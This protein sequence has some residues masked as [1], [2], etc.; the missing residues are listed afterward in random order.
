MF[1]TENRGLPETGW[2]LL[3]LSMKRYLLLNLKINL[4]SEIYCL[5]AKYCLPKSCQMIIFSYV[6]TFLQEFFFHLVSSANCCSSTAKP[7]RQAVEIA[8][9]CSTIGLNSFSLSNTLCKEGSQAE[10]HG[11][12]PGSWACGGEAALSSPRSTDNKSSL[13]RRLLAVSLTHMGSDVA[14]PEW[15][16]SLSPLHMDSQAEPVQ[17]LPFP[18]CRFPAK[19]TTVHSHPTSKTKPC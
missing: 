5:V 18:D 3:P 10:T 16:N 13:M 17:Y 12:A 1:S 19:P 2:Y 9:T 6:H 7:T 15:C 14:L 11:R 8:G 4:F